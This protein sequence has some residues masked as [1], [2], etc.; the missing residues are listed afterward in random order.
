MI[1][2]TG[3]YLE[4][5]QLINP[6]ELSSILNLIEQSNFKD[7][8]STASENA[9]N[10]KN[11]LQIN[12]ENNFHA[13]QIGQIVHQAISKNRRIQSAILPKVI[14]PPLVSQY[15]SGMHYGLHVDSPLMG[16]QFTIR[17]DVGMTLFLSDPSSYEGGELEIMTEFGLQRF[18]LSAGSAVIYPTTRLHQVLPVTQGKRLAVVTWMQCAIREANKREI[19]DQINQVLNELSV[20]DHK[21]SHLML[22]QIYSNLIRMWAE[23]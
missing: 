8:K 20:T 23:I 15:E 16:N 1:I 4:L 17:T 2:E 9:A 11:N 12:S 6:S 5:T 18:K 19:I 7:G 22:Q 21:E 13:Q 3:N 10:V 14:L